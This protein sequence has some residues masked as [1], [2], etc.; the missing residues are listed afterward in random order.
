MEEKKIA[1]VSDYRK[2][3]GGEQVVTLPSGAVF[4][5]RKLSVMDYLENG[6]DEIPNEFLQYIEDAQSGKLA[7]MSDEEQAEI[8]K[9]NTGFFEQ[10]L[11]VSI[12]IGVIEPSIILKYDKDKVGDCLIF[13]ELTQE[14]QEY[15]IN[16]ITGR[17]NGESIQK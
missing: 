17:I 11:D 9:K 5:V 15:L 4:K 12:R 6:L 8:L 3:V 14:D 1:S 2:K 7:K 13:S 10:Y 16:V